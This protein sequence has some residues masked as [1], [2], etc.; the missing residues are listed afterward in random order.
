MGSVLCCVSMQE[1]NCSLMFFGDKLFEWCLWK[2]SCKILQ[3]KKYKTNVNG[4]I[5]PHNTRLNSSITPRT[6]HRAL[7]ALQTWL[8][9]K[10]IWSANNY[11]SSTSVVALFVGFPNWKL[12]VPISTH[13]PT[14]CKISLPYL[15]NATRRFAFNL[16][17][18]VFQMTCK[19]L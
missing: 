15:T 4:A 17:C 12:N 7:K 10:M 6:W 19:K 14:S 8:T 11:F 9:P 2:H 18:F 16:F 13:Q 1:K 3:K 5:A